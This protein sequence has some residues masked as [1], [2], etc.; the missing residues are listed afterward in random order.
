MKKTFSFNKLLLEIYICIKYLKQENLTL[1]LL[2][3]NTL[4]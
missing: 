2:E 1:S 3:K 4:L